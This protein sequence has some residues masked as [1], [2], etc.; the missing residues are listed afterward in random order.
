MALGLG[1]EQAVEGIAVVQRQI[2]NRQPAL[3]A[4]KHP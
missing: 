4:G 3:L 1:D 2:G